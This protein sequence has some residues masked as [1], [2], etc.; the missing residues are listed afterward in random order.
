MKTLPILASILL[1]V[2][3]A[4]PKQDSTAGTASGTAATQTNAIRPVYVDVRTPEEYA[5]GHVS[6][7]ILIPHDQ[8]AARWQE[9]E[10]YRDTPVVVYCRSGRRSDLALQVLKEK[11]FTNVENGGGL[12]DLQGQGV[13]VE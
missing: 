13:P 6:G 8:M 3:C 10:A 11:G 2:G 1:L 12:D 4:G 7:A 9:L 5:S